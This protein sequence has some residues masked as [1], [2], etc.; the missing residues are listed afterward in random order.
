MQK[1]GNRAPSRRAVLKSTTGLTLSG[2]VAFLGGAARAVA[3]DGLTPVKLPP[4][5]ASSER[6]SDKVPTP[7]PP[8]QRVGF[9]IVGLGH[10]ALQQILPAFSESKLC[11]PVALVSGDGAKAANVAA[12]YGIAPKHVYD[13][14]SYDRLAQDAAV[15][16]VYVVLPNGLHAEYSI[17]AARAG[18]HVLC[19][20]PM[21]IS[22]NECERMIDASRAAHKKLMVAYRMQYEPYNR[23]AIR[24]ARAGELGKLKAFMASNGQA[25]GDPRQWR[26]RKALAGGGSLPDVGIYC[27]NAARYLSGEE[28]TEVSALVTSTPHDPRFVEVEEQ[29]DFTLR[30]PS[31]FVASCTSS[32]GY[33]DSKC[34]RLMGTQGWLELDPAFPYAGQAMRI[35]RKHAG[36]SGEDVETRKLEAKNQFALEMDHFAACIRDDKVPLTGGEEGL[37]DMR[38]IA[39]IY[40]SARRG[41]VVKLPRIEK[42]DALRGPALVDAAG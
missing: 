5:L 37:Q 13:Y 6:E 16:A 10:L 14:Q 25:Q 8:E 42:V 2:A 32:Y 38:V 4:L 3:G 9:A 41:H 22:V 18:K 12:Q 11:R 28:P 24:M 34:Y 27:L 36:S 30:F 39:A 7:L 20:K 26:L 33:H 21:A 19:E 31:G 40:D 23:E 17:R 1:R 15:S 29:V 35:A